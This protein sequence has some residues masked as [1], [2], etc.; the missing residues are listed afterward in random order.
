MVVLCLMAAVHCISAFFIEL[1]APW[2]TCWPVCAGEGVH[3]E[4]VILHMLVGVPGA[5]RLLPA[6]PRESA[7]AGSAAEVA[8]RDGDARGRGSGSA[9]TAAPKP[10]ALYEGGS[11]SEV[12]ERAADA[13]AATAAAAAKPRASKRGDRRAGAE[14]VLLFH[15]VCGWAEGQLEGAVGGRGKHAGQASSADWPLQMFHTD[16]LLFVTALPKPRPGS[17]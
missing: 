7:N 16:R 5:T 14:Q 1:K 11:L 6:V 17:N 4:V 12:L 8:P 10:A 3:H 9:G 15:G 13:A 2:P